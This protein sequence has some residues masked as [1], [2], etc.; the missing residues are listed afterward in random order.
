[1]SKFHPIWCLIAQES[2]LRRKFLG[3]QTYPAILPD[4]STEIGHIRSK[5]G[6]VHWTFST[7]TFDNSFGHILLTGCLID[8]IL[9]P[10]RL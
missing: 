9:F 4:I 2:K 1:V 5:V 6:Y 10:M 7:A 8:P 3:D